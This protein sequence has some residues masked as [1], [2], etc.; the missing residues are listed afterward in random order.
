M[1]TEAHWLFAFYYMRIARNMPKVIA[2]S[3]EPQKNYQAVFW[4]GTAINAVMTLSEFSGV[5]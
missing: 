4:A 1:F 2:Q 5:L 3:D